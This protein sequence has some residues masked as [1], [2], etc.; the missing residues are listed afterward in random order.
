MPRPYRGAQ[1]AACLPVQQPSQLGGR[2]GGVQLC[3]SA[4]LIEQPICDC[5]RS[6]GLSSEAPLPSLIFISL[7]F[8]LFHLV[9]VVS[10]ACACS[11]CPKRNNLIS[12]CQC[13]CQSQ[14]SQ[15][16]NSGRHLHLHSQPRT[17]REGV[18][19]KNS[20]EPGVYSRF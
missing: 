2:D 20:G 12:L 17:G 11:N 3:Q 19:G 7:Y 9:A 16:G 8:A 15:R 5:V 6:L 14:V 4:A 10:C 18:T 13:Q 1:P